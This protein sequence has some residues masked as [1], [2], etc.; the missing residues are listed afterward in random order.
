[1]HT[2]VQSSVENKAAE[3]AGPDFIKV[4]YYLALKN[5]CLKYANN[6]IVYTKL[7]LL[8]IKS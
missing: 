1:M 4:T 5:V 6:F 2:E 3:K 7:M 8:S